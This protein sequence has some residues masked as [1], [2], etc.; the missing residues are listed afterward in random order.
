MIIFDSVAFPSLLN[1]IPHDIS[2][3]YGKIFFHA[4]L[5]NNKKELLYEYLS[6]FL[7]IN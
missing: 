5:A 7:L 4:I 2:K 1:K 6:L 3:K